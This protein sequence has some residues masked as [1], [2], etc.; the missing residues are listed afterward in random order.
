MVFI[1]GGATAT[2]NIPVSGTLA[3]G[4]TMLPYANNFTCAT[5][6]SYAPLTG[7]VI[8][9]TGALVSGAVTSG[10]GIYFNLCYICQ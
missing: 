3:S 1:S 2:A 5:D 8:T 10:K 6:E 9:T 7:V 4:I